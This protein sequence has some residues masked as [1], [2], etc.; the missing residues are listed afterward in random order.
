MFSRRGV[1]AAITPLDRA[2]CGRADG[3]G[4]ICR[5]GET[6]ESGEAANA[7][8]GEG[9]CTDAGE[10]ARASNEP[11]GTPYPFSRE[12]PGCDMGSDWIDV[13]DDG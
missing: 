11:R 1:G 8:L 6:A 9:C 5:A 12:S 3:V 7:D 4:V 2:G 13:T 10:A